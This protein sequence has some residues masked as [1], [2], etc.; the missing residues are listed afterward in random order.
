MSEENRE[1]PTPHEQPTVEEEA[2]AGVRDKAQTTLAAPDLPYRPRDP[3]HYRPG[4]ALIGSGGITAAHLT[5]YQAAGYN[6]IAVCDVDEKRAIERRDAFY[7]N[8]SVCTDYR[9]VLRRDDVEVVDIATHPA[10][11]V[12]LIEAALQARKHVL[13]QKPFVLDL[14]TGERLCEL[15]EKQ[16]VKLAVN[17]NGRWAPHVAYMRLAVAAGL[18]GDVTSADLAVSFDHSW[19]VGTP[20]DDIYD[21][22][23]YDFAIHWFD[24]LTC[25]LP[26]QSASRVAASAAMAKGQLPKPP[27]LA[28]VLVDYPAAQATLSFNAATRYGQHDRTYL[29]GSRATA[30]SFGPGLQDQTLH[31]TTA[32]GVMSPTLVGHWFNDGFHGTMGELLCAIEEDRTP[33]N[34]ALENL[35]S[36]ALAFAAIGSAHDGQPKRPGDVRRLP[37][38]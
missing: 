8:A 23:L 34:N 5:A 33:S 15:A 30:H 31:I 38:V 17:Q 18:L 16:G 27:L 22:I 2:Y 13:S 3:K 20:F 6:V 29:V 28:H 25:Y 9:D 12:A 35:R 32:D 1:T 24:M 21:L 10:A 36:L 19:V 4:I 11:R 7:P 26:D 14:D 37:G